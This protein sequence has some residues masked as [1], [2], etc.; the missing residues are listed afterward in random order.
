MKER[1]EQA[2]RA[3][4]QRE[5][6]VSDMVT[7]L[8]PAIEKALADAICD[9]REA[10]AQVADE[11]DHNENAE[12]ATAWRIAKAIRDRG[13]PDGR[14]LRARI[15]SALAGVLPEGAQVTVLLPGKVD[16]ATVTIGVS[17]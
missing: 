12:C 17:S 16:K 15:E 8:W 3:L 11:E 1:L 14:P 10:C 9:E 13:K 5:R 4:P 6:S 2:A 7:D